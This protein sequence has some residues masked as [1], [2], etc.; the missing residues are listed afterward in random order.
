MNYDITPL[1]VLEILGAKPS[2][3]FE[4]I[5]DVPALLND[6][7]SLASKQKI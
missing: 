6:F 7:L 4:P 3:E 1:E 2:D 5:S